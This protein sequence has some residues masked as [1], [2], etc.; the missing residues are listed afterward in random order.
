MA[1]LNMNVTPEF[2]EALARLMR[3]RRIRNKSAA[4]R[5][6]VS[7]ALQRSLAESTSFDWSAM[8]GRAS[9]EE[10]PKRRF[11]SDADLWEKS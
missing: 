6:A 9:G 4:I 10:N 8:A 1:Q 5:I 2:E 7:E 3:I 11:H